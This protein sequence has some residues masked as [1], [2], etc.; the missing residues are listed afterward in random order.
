MGATNEKRER[1][2]YTIQ[3]VT[4]SSVCDKEVPPIHTLKKFEI[5]LRKR[6]DLEIQV[7][8]VAVFVPL[9]QGVKIDGILWTI[10]RVVERHESVSK[11]TIWDEKKATFGQQGKREE[12][13]KK[14][15]LT[16]I[17]QFI[18]AIATHAP[19]SHVIVSHFL[20]LSSSAGAVHECFLVGVMD[21]FYNVSIYR[22]QC[23]P[24]SQR[25]L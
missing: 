18:A 8:M 7:T 15:R 1:H 10:H 5:L 12:K 2:Q 23:L 25:A 13:G 3:S 11:S 20:F 24:A 19:T 9:S 6:H 16:H 17:F 14:G 22:S 4:Q 21:G